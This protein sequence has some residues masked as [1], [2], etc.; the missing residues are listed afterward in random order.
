[1]AGKRSRGTSGTRC[2]TTS[3]V[4]GQQPGLSGI[5]EYVEQIV[6]SAPRFTARQRAAIAAILH[7]DEPPYRVHGRASG[8]TKGN[9]T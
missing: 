6:R 1:M 2:R 9:A 7:G 4:T 8:G 3:R 5:D